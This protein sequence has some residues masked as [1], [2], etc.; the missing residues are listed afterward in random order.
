[1]K[2]LV[3]FLFLFTFDSKA[4][5][6][7][8]RNT[9]SKQ[10]Y[11]PVVNKK[12]ERT[13]AVNG[14]AVPPDAIGYRIENGFIEFVFEKS[15]SKFRSAGFPK[16][17]QL[18]TD[19]SQKDDSHNSEGARPS[20]PSGTSPGL[21]HSTA[22]PEASGEE[23][24]TRPSASRRD[25]PTPGEVKQDR[26]PTSFSE[27]AETLSKDLFPSG[28]KGNPGFPYKVLGPGF[29][30]KCQATL[31]S[32]EGGLCLAATAAHCLYDGASRALDKG[33][34]QQAFDK[35]SCDSK[36]KDRG[37][38]WGKGEIETA[39]FGKVNATFFV[40]PEYHSGTKSEDSAVFGFPCK[41][42]SSVPVVSLGKNPLENGEKVFY[43]KVMGGKEG[44]YEGVVAREPD[45]VA[46]NSRPVGEA[47]ESVRQPA[48]VHIQQGDS[49][50]GIYR[51][52]PS[53]DFEL[54]GVLS[55]SDDVRKQRPIG[56]YATNKSLDFIQCILNIYSKAPS[57]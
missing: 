33:I 15:N 28:T 37:L 22:R 8:L 27:Q 10:N 17:S 5:F 54:V 12:G 31:I 45:V 40:N 32:N 23:E 1:M 25:A 39:D 14:I 2:I 53:G 29:S 6:K 7:H 21:N 57:S 48:G 55:T 20:A 19:S 36:V 3:L 42:K 49:G 26:A 16:G 13:I 41:D 18:N 52:K 35:S 46:I 51:K 34:D 9:K 43:G 56:N 50:G 24:S 47:Q 11:R 44:L 38:F 30:E 4:E